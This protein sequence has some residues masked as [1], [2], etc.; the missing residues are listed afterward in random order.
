MIP[1]RTRT[2]FRNWLPWDY[3]ARAERKLKGRYKAGYIRNVRHERKPPV[4]AIIVELIAMAK[5]HRQE[6]QELMRTM[7][8]A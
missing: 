3:A 5:E 4:P 7:K 8:N 6:R 2:L 1:E